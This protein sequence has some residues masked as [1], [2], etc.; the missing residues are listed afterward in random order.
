MPEIKGVPNKWLE[1]NMGN[2]TVRP[3]SDLSRGHIISYQYHMISHH[4]TSVMYHTLI[5]SFINFSLLN[6]VYFQCGISAPD[7]NR[8]ESFPDGKNQAGLVL[9]G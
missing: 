2:Q 1:K 3:V 7:W 6:T 8:S 9:E 4:I 5:C